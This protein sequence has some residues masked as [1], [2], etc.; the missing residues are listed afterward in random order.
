MTIT[1]KE[2]V[3]ES[4][5]REI[6]MRVAASSPPEK[7]AGAI[8]GCLEQGKEVAL[9]AIG[10]GAVNQAVKGQI[11]ARAICARKGWNLYSVFGFSDAY[12]NDSHRSAIKF[13]VR[14]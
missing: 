7:L 12:S 1:Q 14:K 10:A 9:V 2:E 6:T 4:D 13:F 8:V 3:I 5:S 11:L